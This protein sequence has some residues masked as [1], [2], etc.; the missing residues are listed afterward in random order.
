MEMG[1]GREG[2]E[3]ERESLNRRPNGRLFGGRR[4]DPKL[5]AAYEGRLILGSGILYR[6]DTAINL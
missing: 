1:S 3:R 4:N 6:R 5:R 2:G